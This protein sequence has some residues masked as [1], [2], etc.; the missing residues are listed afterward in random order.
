MLASDIAAECA[1]LIVDE[2][3]AVAEDQF[4]STEGQLGRDME[5]RARQVHVIRVEPGENVSG[6]PAQARIDGSGLAAV[7][8][9]DPVRQMLLVS[10]DHLDA[11]VC[12]PPI[13]DDAFQVGILLAED[14]QDRLFQEPS[15]LV[16]GGDDGDSGPVH[17]R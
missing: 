15:L 6:C 3:Q 17:A 13:H 10:L 7:L 11:V 4:R 1:R 5:E 12:A 2:V 16:R 14:G 8:L 9:A